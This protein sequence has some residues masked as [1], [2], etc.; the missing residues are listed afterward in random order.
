MSHEGQMRRG[1]TI[2]DET[3]PDRIYFLEN[4]KPASTKETVKE[5]KVDVKKEK[6]KDDN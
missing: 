3:N 5:T 6:K 1:A 2:S 4:S